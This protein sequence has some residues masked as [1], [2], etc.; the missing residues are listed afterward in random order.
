MIPYERADLVLTCNL[1]PGKEQESH[2]EH[3]PLSKN[4]KLTGYDCVGRVVAF[5][6]SEE[7]VNANTT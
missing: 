7:N 5:K 2:F 4:G 6:V 1:F 3:K